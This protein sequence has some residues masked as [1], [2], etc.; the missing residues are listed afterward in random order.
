MSNFKQ[1]DKVIIKFK[2]KNYIHWHP[3][4][5]NL[6][7]QEVEYFCEGHFIIGTCFVLHPSGIDQG[8]GGGWARG[9]YITECCLELVSSSNKVSTFSKTS[10]DPMC[11]RCNGKLIKKEAE[12]P[13]TG[14]KY[15]IEKCQSCGWC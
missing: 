8:I 11:P 2:D 7:G 15:M 13:F 10:T 14:K 5:D 1:G 12:E 9:W 6:V 3:F 4:M